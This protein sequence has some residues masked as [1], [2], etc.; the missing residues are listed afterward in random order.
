MGELEL[1][2]GEWETEEFGLG[3]GRLP[4]KEEIFRAAWR[5]IFEEAWGEKGNWNPKSEEEM[6][7]VLA[8][9]EGIGGLGVAEMEPRRER[10]AQLS[11]SLSLA[12]FSMLDLATPRSQC[13][14]R[15]IGMSE[16]AQKRWV[17]ILALEKVSITLGY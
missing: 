3:Y 9:G 1:E 15:K 16:K 5:Q 13:L 17:L 8:G 6:E 10:Q 14:L 11:F 2:G 12:V 7:V 4:S